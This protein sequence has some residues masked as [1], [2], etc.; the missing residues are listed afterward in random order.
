MLCDSG[1]CHSFGFDTL[2]SRAEGVA[3][4]RS[5]VR[6]CVAYSEPNQSCRALNGLSDDTAPRSFSGFLNAATMIFPSPSLSN[7]ANSPALRLQATNHR[8]AGQQGNKC[9][10]LSRPPST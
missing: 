3:A 10:H 4:N 5:K 2:L 8:Q 1:M 7:I 6:E 9:R